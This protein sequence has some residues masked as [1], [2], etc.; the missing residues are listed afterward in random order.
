MSGI[1]NK[2]CYFSPGFFSTVPK[3]STASVSS[4]GKALQ[5]AILWMKPANFSASRLHL[6][7]HALTFNAVKHCECKAWPAKWRRRTISSDER[8]WRP[9]PE[10]LILSRRGGIGG[11]VVRPAPAVGHDD[12]K[13]LF[14]SSNQCFCTNICSTT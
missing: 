5:H 8:A 4:L 2:C 12:A 6:V 13:L 11:K 10:V 9:D 7:H 3:C 14:C 1:R